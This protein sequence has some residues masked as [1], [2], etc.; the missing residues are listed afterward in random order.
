MQY[1]V[2]VPSLTSLSYHFSFHFISN[3]KP[4]FHILVETDVQSVFELVLC[5]SGNVPSTRLRGNWLL[6]LMMQLIGDF[7]PMIVDTLM[8]LMHIF[9][10]KIPCRN[11]A[12]FY[13][14]RLMD[15]CYQNCLFALF[16]FA[17]IIH[18]GNELNHIFGRKKNI[19]WN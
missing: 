11:R 13:M 5:C 6:L 2:F 4:A 14:R 19:D 12:K 15:F 1:S 18:F 16:F 7:A 10:R 17:S 8:W 9:V 3:G